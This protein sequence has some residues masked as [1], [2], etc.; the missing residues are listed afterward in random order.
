LKLPDQTSAGWRYGI[1]IGAFTLIGVMA[2]A[3]LLI[4]SEEGV[5]GA[6]VFAEAAVVVIAIAAA[7]WLI[8]G[9]L[10]RARELDLR[11]ASSHESAQ[12]W[13]EE[14]ETLLLGLGASIDRQFGR[15]R[16]SGAE[17][18]VALLLLKGLAHKDIARMRGISEA[19]AGQQAT[20]VYRKAGVEGRNDLAAFF[21]EDLALPQGRDA[22]SPDAFE[23][24]RERTKRA[25]ASSG[26]PA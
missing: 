10:I 20:A 21:L 9:L 22:V 7:A 14:A 15:W 1:L 8:R 16:L 24:N 11:L 6:H 5:S 4:D 19:T 18:E 17:K 25:D 23:P 2:G 3:D 13:R 26:R 12:A